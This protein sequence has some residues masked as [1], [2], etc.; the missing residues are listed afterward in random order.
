M[1]F[2]K[3]RKPVMFYFFAAN[4]FTIESRCLWR[5]EGNWK[6]FPIVS[7]SGMAL[8]VFISKWVYV[9]HSETCKQPSV[10]LVHISECEI[11]EINELTS[12]LWPRSSYSYSS[13]V[14]RKKKRQ[15]VSHLRIGRHGRHL[16][17]VK[18]HQSQSAI[19]FHSS[20]SDMSRYLN[21]IYV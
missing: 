17:D 13:N 5:N 11:H 3:I 15:S 16:G 18:L 4:A 10:D 21:L 6:P 7:R 2:C 20:R 8:I 19:S 9:S 1:K 14:Q 12:K